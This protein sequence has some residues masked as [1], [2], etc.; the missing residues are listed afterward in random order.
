MTRHARAG[1]R[2]AWAWARAMGGVIKGLGNR[3]WNGGVV[4]GAMRGV[5]EGLGGRVWGDV[6]NVRT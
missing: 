6:P 5:M 4:E 2:V 1:E 3:V